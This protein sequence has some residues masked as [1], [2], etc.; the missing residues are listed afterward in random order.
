MPV[1]RQS[2]NQNQGPHDQKSG[3]LRLENVVLAA[4][5]R[6]W[7]NLVADG[8]QAPQYCSAALASSA[9]TRYR[10]AGGESSTHPRYCK[11]CSG[12]KTA[13]LRSARTRRRP[14]P[15]RP[16]V[17]PNSQMLNFGLPCQ[18]HT[19]VSRERRCVSGCSRPT[20]QRVNC[21]RMASEYVCRSN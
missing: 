6:G 2:E 3:S 11:P 5:Y 13:E 21:A 16:V 17:R 15:T 19:A 4:P 10:A 8:L 18:Y 14:V 1:T 9:L 12:T 7:T 20:S